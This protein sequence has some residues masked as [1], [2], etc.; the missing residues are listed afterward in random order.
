MPFATTQTVFVGCSGNPVPL[1]NRE[2]SA[3]ERPR[4]RS[5]HWDRSWLE[6]FA[7]NARHNGT[8]ALQFPVLRQRRQALFQP[9]GVVGLTPVASEFC[10]APALVPL[11]LR[12][13]GSL[14]P[15]SQPDPKV[16]EDV[17]DN[18][19]ENIGHDLPP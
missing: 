17:G 7:E 4:W 11:S 8:G 13:L 16:E 14:S 9:G 10:E 6:P 12:A 15:P 3:R 5:R 1:Q 2:I 19:Q 18:I